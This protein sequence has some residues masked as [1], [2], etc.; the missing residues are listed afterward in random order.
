MEGPTAEHGWKHG[1][2]EEKHGP[3]RPIPVTDLEKHGVGEETRGGRVGMDVE[4]GLVCVS[5]C[6]SP[7]V[8][9]VWVCACE[10]K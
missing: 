10:I 6:V 3:G 5:L 2:G 4:R 7:C 8:L 1:V 9:W